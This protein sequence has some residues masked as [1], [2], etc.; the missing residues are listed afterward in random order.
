MPQIETPRTDAEFDLTGK[1]RSG[2]PNLGLWLESGI[3]PNTRVLEH[4]LIFPTVIYMPWYEQRFRSYDFWK[5][6]R[7]AEI[8]V[9]SK[10]WVIWET[11]TF[12]RK[13]DAISWNF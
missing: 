4:F 5:F 3:D 8:S 10:N 1:Q 2:I 11:W 13:S 9:L 12:D 6:N 7:V